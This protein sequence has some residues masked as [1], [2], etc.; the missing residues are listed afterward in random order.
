MCCSALGC[1][2]RIKQFDK[3]PEA[4]RLQ[5][6]S[7][8]VLAGRRMRGPGGQ[9]SIKQVS[10]D[11]T[12]AELLGTVDLPGTSPFKSKVK[13]LRQLAQSAWHIGCVMSFLRNQGKEPL[14]VT[15]NRV[16]KVPLGVIVILE[17]REL[18]RAYL[19]SLKELPSL[20]KQGSF[21]MCADCLSAQPG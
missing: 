13:R 9:Y 4:V 12:L 16:R 11:T 19:S 15:V 14:V 20:D 18:G 8:C 6:Y 7:E 1:P 17:C 10:D 5:Y 21:V 2:P 3:Q